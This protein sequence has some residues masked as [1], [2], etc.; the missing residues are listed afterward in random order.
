[1]AMPTQEA[2]HQP[3][4][5]RV[6]IKLEDS[7]A[8]SP[9]SFVTASRPGSPVQFETTRRYVSGQSGSFFVVVVVVVVHV[10]LNQLACLDVFPSL[11]SHS[12]A[13]HS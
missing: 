2:F 6:S 12:Q 1:M 11:C 13:A 9:E 8:P 3:K 4:E 10:W 7:R 5:V